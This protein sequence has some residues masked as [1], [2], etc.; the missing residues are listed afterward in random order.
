MP[1]MC[2]H[3]AM[4][5]SCMPGAVAGPGCAGAPSIFDQCCEEQYYVRNSQ[6]RSLIYNQARAGVPG[7]QD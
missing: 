2:C 1:V 5:Q 7:L 6:T 4:H 3:A